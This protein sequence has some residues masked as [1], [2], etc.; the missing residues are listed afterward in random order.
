MTILLAG[1]H[2]CGNGGGGV[3]LYRLTDSLQAA[4]ANPGSDG[5]RCY[6]ASPGYLQQQNALF[7]HN[8]KTPRSLMACVQ[9]KTMLADHGNLK[10]NV[11][12]AVAQK[13][14]TGNRITEE[15]LNVLG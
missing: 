13:R 1:N 8:S 2:P 5:I 4:C 3:I 10:L 14:E 6:P 11:N 9:R 12:T 15:L 7:T